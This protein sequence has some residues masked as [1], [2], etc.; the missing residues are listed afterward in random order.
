MKLDRNQKLEVYAKLLNVSDPDLLNKAD[1]AEKIG[2]NAQALG[3]MIGQLKTNAK[4][5]RDLEDLGYT[6]KQIPDWVAAGVAPTP[7]VETHVLTGSPRVGVATKIGQTS[8]Q[9]GYQ[10][11]N[12]ASNQASNQLTTTYNPPTGPMEGVEGV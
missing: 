6:P 8:N 5:R 9:P 12:Q 3:G 2:I 10:P 11:G 4:M 7:L 1:F